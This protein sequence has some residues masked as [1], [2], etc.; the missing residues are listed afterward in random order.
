MS[1]GLKKLNKAEA[2][3]TLLSAYH[4]DILELIEIDP[5]VFSDPDWATSDP[6]AFAAYQTNQ[7]RKVLKLK[8]SEEIFALLHEQIKD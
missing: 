1:V 6:R 5:K 8:S 4:E 2:V 3:R 7:Y